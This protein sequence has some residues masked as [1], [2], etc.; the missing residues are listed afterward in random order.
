MALRDL[1]FL[2]LRQ[3]THESIVSHSSQTAC[4]QRGRLT[5]KRESIAGR[6]LVIL[7]CWWS[8]FKQMLSEFICKSNRSGASA[9]FSVEKRGL[10]TWYLSGACP[11]LNVLAV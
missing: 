1:T 11:S 6:C 5:E 2:D 3:I 10:D 9:V 4:V 8:C 7:N